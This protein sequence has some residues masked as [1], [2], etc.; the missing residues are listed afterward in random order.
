MNTVD[1]AERSVTFLP[2]SNEIKLGRS[3]LP[4]RFVSS[5][6]YQRAGIVNSE[7]GSSLAPPPQ[8]P[9]TVPTTVIE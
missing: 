3:V 1:N 8:P 2:I 6:K 4:E 9:A 5:S 7:L